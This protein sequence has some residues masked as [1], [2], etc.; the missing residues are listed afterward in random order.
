MNEFHQTI[1]EGYGFVTFESFEDAARVPKQITVQ[2][3]NFLCSLTHKHNP[4]FKHGGGMGMGM[5]SNH[6]GSSGMGG[7]PHQHHQHGQFQHVNPYGGGSIHSGNGSTHFGGHSNGIINDMGMGTTIS[8]EHSGSGEF[9]TYDSHDIS[10]SILGRLESLQVIAPS[11]FSNNNTGNG[12]LGLNAKHGP[13]GTNSTS[14]LSQNSQI[15]HVGSIS[16]SGNLNA[17]NHLNYA[18]NHGAGYPLSLNGPIPSSSFGNS[19]PP[20][21]LS[22]VDRFIG[23][24]P[25]SLNVPGT[26]T[27]N[28]SPGSV[29]PAPSGYANR[30]NGPVLGNSFDAPLPNHLDYEVTISNNP[31]GGDISGLDFHQDTNE[32]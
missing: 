22:I 28:S 27:G 5:G 11:G 12:L 29:P 4:T 30:S 17:S 8:R 24:T 18:S 7:R 13:L 26:S 14:H 10:P 9:G 6:H 3:I 21:N 32:Q 15:Q 20:A 1:Q 16:G 31:D 23:F 19:M 25:N 2:G